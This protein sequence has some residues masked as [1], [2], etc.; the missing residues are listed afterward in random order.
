[1]GIFSV[2]RPSPSKLIFKALPLYLEETE[3]PI[4]RQVMIAGDSSAFLGISDRQLKTIVTARAITSGCIVSAH[5]SAK[6]LSNKKFHVS[7]E[8]YMRFRGTILKEVVGSIDI[9]NDKKIKNEIGKYLEI[10]KSTEM[11][12]TELTAKCIWSNWGAPDVD[13]WKQ[14]IALLYNDALSQCLDA[15]NK[16][17]GQK[18]LNKEDNE[19][20]RLIVQSFGINVGE[21]HWGIYT[22]FLEEISSLME[23]KG[24]S[25]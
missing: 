17:H 25:I 8:E 19:K 16:N 11:A 6:H 9:D 1:M 2:F 23:A 10:A 20:L 15:G 22:L 12:V 4:R 24:I 5:S 18:S 13:M 21:S 7:E 3:K 14:G